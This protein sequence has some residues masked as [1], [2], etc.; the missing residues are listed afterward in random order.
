MERREFLKLSTLFAASILLADS[1]LQAI[2][3]IADNTKVV[4]Y[5]IQNT[6]GQWKVLWTKYLDMPKKRVDTRFNRSTF[7]I[8]DIVDESIAN[9][10]RKQL[11]IQYQCSGNAG[12]P[13]NVEKATKA[14]IH[15]WNHTN[16]KEYQNSDRK[17]S[18]IAKWCSSG[19]KATEQGKKN[20]ESGHWKEVQRAG[21]DA[22]I[23]KYKGTQEQSRWSSRG[24]KNSAIT[25][26]ERGNF[27]KLGK[28]ATERHRARW[29]KILKEMPLTFTKAEL[30]DKCT[31]K[32]SYNIINSDLVEHISG[33]GVPFDPKIYA[34]KPA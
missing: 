18:S 2:A 3:K 5:L 26:K 17:K 7:Q 32:M 31:G 21:T 28:Q 22:F 29:I 9:Q 8:L 34:K 30:A 20:V 27:D 33:K 13:I 10:R 19:G 1:K 14:G 12:A 6:K 16:T 4:L 11:W 25:N 15:V 24:G 23:E